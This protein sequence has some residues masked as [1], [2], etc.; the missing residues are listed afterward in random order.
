MTDLSGMPS[1]KQV[2]GVPRI[3]AR[4]SEVPELHVAAVISIISITL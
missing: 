1:F 3:Q 2:T 4:R